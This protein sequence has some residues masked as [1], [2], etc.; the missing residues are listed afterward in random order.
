MT[1]GRHSFDTVFVLTLFCAFIATALL[2]VGIGCRIYKSTAASADAEY[3]LRTSLSYVSG[4][5]HGGS[6]DG[7]RLLSLEG[8]TALELDENIDGADYVTYIYYSDGALRELFTEKDSGV[9]L[10]LGSEIVALSGF[11]FSQDG[12]LL[13]IRAVADGGEARKQSVYIGGLA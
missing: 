5:L 12:E 3:Q 7:A 1:R 13:T 4:R 2:T 10:S 8:V 11:E 6:S 9:S